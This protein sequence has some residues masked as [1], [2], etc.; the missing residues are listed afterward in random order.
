MCEHLFHRL[1]AQEIPTSVTTLVEVFLGDVINGERDQVLRP[2]GDPQK[3]A[4]GTYDVH[5][6]ANLYMDYVIVFQ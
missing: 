2:G 4:L 6:L 5:E 1:L 3:T